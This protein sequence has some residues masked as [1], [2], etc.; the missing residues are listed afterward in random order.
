MEIE[1]ERDVLK[2]KGS[3]LVADSS[4]GTMSA[5]CISD[6]MMT[7]G[8]KLTQNVAVYKTPGRRGP[9]RSALLYIV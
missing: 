7:L 3:T 1:L 2:D 4:G 6:K 5:E 8:R 9:H